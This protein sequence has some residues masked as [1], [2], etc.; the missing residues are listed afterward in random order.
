[1]SKLIAFQQEYGTDARTG[2][3]LCN[4]AEIEW[5]TPTVLS[6]PWWKVI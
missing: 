3:L 4:G 2:L 5:L 6:A 1:V